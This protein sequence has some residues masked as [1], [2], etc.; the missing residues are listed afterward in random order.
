MAYYHASYIR[1]DKAFP[2]DKLVKFGWLA[3]VVAYNEGQSPSVAFIGKTAHRV[4]RLAQKEAISW[5]MKQAK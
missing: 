5:C 1:S 2:K 4:I 3:R